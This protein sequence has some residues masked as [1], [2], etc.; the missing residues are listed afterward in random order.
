MGGSGFAV[1]GK[2]QQAAVREETSIS[3]TPSHRHTAMRVITVEGV[4]GCSG[5]SSLKPSTPS[6]RSP[7]LTVFLW[8]PTRRAPFVNSSVVSSGFIF[9]P[10]SLR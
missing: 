3:P 1:E 6:T 7:I 9:F 5:C 10:G 4:G 8:E 2:P